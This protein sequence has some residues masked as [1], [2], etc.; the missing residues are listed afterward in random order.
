MRFL[1]QGDRDV[2]AMLAA[3]G[4]ASPADLFSSIPDELRLRRDLS[5]PPPQSELEL[6]RRMGGMAASNASAATHACFLGAGAYNHYIPA[7]VW[8][9]LLRSEFYTS[10]TPYQPEISQGTLQATF[11]YQSLIASLTE[12]EISNASLYDGASALAEAVMMAARVTRRNRV[13]VSSAVHPHYREV[14]RS[15]VRNLGITLT[16]APVGPDGRTDLSALRAAAGDGLAA[17]AVQNPSF[18]GCLEDLPAIAGLAHDAG[19]LLIVAINEPLSL[20]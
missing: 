17:I 14:V 15:Y 8:Q 7:A 20:G 1:P 10:Y 6:R 11:E 18:L 16:E 2:R 9:I 5:L 4:A 13:V 12:M 19:A 3:V